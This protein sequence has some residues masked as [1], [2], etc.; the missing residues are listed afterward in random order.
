VLGGGQ[1]A[2]VG[3]QDTQVGGQDTPDGMED[4]QGEK[5]QAVHDDSVPDQEGER[6]AGGQ[7]VPGGDFGILLY[8]VEE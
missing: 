6:T 8:Q 1:D 5:E 2:Q 4:G 3:G 7:H